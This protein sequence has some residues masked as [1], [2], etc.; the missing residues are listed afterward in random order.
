MAPCLTLVSIK[1]C[2]DSF[3][4]HAYYK[5]S[6]ES[7]RLTKL[8]IATYVICLC[9]IDLAETKMWFFYTLLLV[10]I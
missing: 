5:M 2:L 6:T 1:S 9:P 10:H 4:K 7:I 3:V 8:T